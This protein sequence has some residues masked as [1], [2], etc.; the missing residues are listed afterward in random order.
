MRSAGRK[1]LAK[2]DNA[3]LSVTGEW[4]FLRL[5]NETLIGLVGDIQIE[6][7]GY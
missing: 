6:M 1:R 4:N 2:I 5:N 7:H 3:A